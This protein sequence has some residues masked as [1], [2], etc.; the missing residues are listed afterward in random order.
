MKNEKGVDPK[1]ISEREL[2]K[3]IKTKIL[4]D[5]LVSDVTAKGIASVFPRNFPAAYIDAAM[6]AMDQ[7]NKFVAVDP[8]SRMK[9][10]QDYIKHL[11]EKKESYSEERFIEVY[12]SALDVLAMIEKEILSLLH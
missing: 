2:T 8:L 11:L 10:Q 6:Q 1:V 12:N 9:A 4:N 7:Y 3:F 5:C